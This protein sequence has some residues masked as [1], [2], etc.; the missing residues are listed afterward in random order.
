MLIKTAKVT[1][2]S[3]SRDMRSGAF[4]FMKRIANT[5]A[6]F[7]EA[8]FAELLDV[9][10][11]PYNISNNPDDYMFLVA[12]ALTADVPNENKDAFGEYELLSVKEAGVFTYE[13][14]R[15]TP[16]LEEHDDSDIPTV[17]GGFNIDAYYD[18]TN[19]DDKFV[20]LLIALDTSKK[21]HIASKILNGDKVDF[22]MGCICMRTRCSKCG[23]IAY[24]EKDFC[25]H[26]KN[27]FAFGKDVFEWCEDVTY[28]ELS[29]VAEPAD[30]NA[31]SIQACYNDGGKIICK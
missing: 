11:K 27:K 14:F 17:A 15:M 4:S 28:R 29:H 12:R 13:T 5:P 7:T 3:A 31:S 1:I 8:K 20:A 25:N 16:L 10:H 22:S 9:V 6:S 21:P 19:S 24:D 30:P 18:D 2:I 23:N 26:V